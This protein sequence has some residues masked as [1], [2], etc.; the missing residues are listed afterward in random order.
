MKLQRRGRISGRPCW[1]RW[2]C[3]AA[4]DAFPVARGHAPWV[5]SVSATPIWGKLQYDVGLH[6]YRT[7]VTERQL[8]ETPAFARQEDQCKDFWR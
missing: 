7:D 4:S 2:G 8:Q 5:Q 6:A 3:S 1:R